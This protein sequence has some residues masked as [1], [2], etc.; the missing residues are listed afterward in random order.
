MQ[1]CPSIILSKYS[2]SALPIPCTHCLKSLLLHSIYSSKLACS[3][4][5][6]W[7]GSILVN[8]PISNKIPAVLLS[9][10]ACDDTS[11]TTQL[12]PASTIWLKYFWIKNDSGVVFLDG[13]CSSP[14]IV[15][16]VPISPAFMLHFSRISRIIKVVVVLPFVPVM[17][18]VLSFL[19]G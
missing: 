18:I 6:I 11:I 10:S 9:M 13:I 7:S 3:L 14:I 19:A 1:V 16:L 12:Q 17:P 4:G 15:S 2:L 5:P 8:T